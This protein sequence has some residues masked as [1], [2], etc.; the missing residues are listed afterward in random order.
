MNSEKTK[1]FADKC[2]SV[3]GDRYRYDNCKYIATHEKVEII[4]PDHGSFW[5]RPSSHLRGSGCPKC[6]GRG[7][8][9]DDWIKRAIST[10]GRKYDYSQ[11]EYAGAQKKSVI[12]CRDH[13]PFSQRLID[14]VSGQGCPACSRYTLRSDMD[15][16]IKKFN[17]VH[18]EVYSYERFEYRGYNR[19]GRITC[20]VHGDFM[21]TPEAHARG[22]GC[23]RCASDNRRGNT[24]VFVE[25]AS[26][27][28]DGAYDYSQC[29][30]L[31][32]ITK[33]KI[34]CPQHGP[35][36]KTPNKHLS[37]Q[38]CPSC[39]FT[40][41]SAVIYVIP[42][43]GMC[44]IGISVD[45][46]RRLKEMDG[47]PDFKEDD[48]FTLNVDSWVKARTIESRIHKELK[49][50]NAGLTGFSGCTEWFHIS[51]EDARNAVM[52]QVS[53]FSAIAP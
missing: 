2:V 23:P 26:R 48:I 32:A 25:K 9:T 27:L 10:H 4:C 53:K 8:T 41:R 34:I 15:R 22:D 36:Y 47:C 21:Q 3:H 11:T 5:Q 49:G 40:D 6:S 33:V 13:G 42:S 46:N 29:E 39:S 18:G 43:S 12:I 35:F 52:L 28:F 16:Y 31:T 7:L 51:E 50:K 20:S 44:K 14:H 24:E 37:G 30:Y 1:L 17:R 45:L 38:G 19:K